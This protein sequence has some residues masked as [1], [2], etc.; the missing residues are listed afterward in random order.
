[1]APVEVEVEAEDE[2]E[3]KTMIKVTLGAEETLEDMVTVA[4]TAASRTT[5]LQ[6]ACDGTDDVI[7]ATPV[8]QEIQ[9]F[10]QWV[11][12]KRD[13]TPFRKQRQIRHFVNSCLVNLSNH[14]D[15]DMSDLISAL[16]SDLGSTRLKE[17]LL[18]PM[19][20]E[21]ADTYP[22]LSFQFVILPLIGALTRESLCQSTMS[23]E[24]NKIYATVYDYRRQFLEEG[25]IPCMDS[26]VQ[27]GSLEDTSIGAAQLLREDPHM[28][29]VT[30]LQ[31]ALLAIVRLF[32]QPLTRIRDAH[33][34][35]RDMVD[36]LSTQV[37]TCAM[38]SNTTGEDRF[39][40]DILARETGRLKRITA[41]AEEAV[42]QH[43]DVATSISSRARGAGVPDMTQLREA[44]DPPGELSPSG[45]RDDNDFV[46]I[47]DISILPTQQEITCT[48]D[49][50]LPSNGIPDA[51]HF[52]PSGWKRQI[53]IH[54][55]CTDHLL[56][57][58]ELR[59]HLKSNTH[60][61][62]YGN[63]KLLGMSTRKNAEGHIDLEFDQPTQV[64]GLGM[65]RRIDFWERSRNRLMHGGLICLM[66]RNVH[67]DASQNHRLIL[68]VI[69][70]R[71]SKAM[72]KNETRANI[73]VVLA[74]VMQFVHLLNTA[75]TQPMERWYIVES[76]G[77]YFGAYQP[78]LKALQNLIP[79]SLPFGKYLAPTAEEG[80][81]MD[82]V[83]DFIDPPIYALAPDFQYDLSVLLDGQ[84][85]NL[86]VRDALSIHEANRLLLERKCLDE[87]QTRALIDTLCREVSIINGPPGTGKTW[88]G[89][90]L[91]R[92]LLATKEASN[93]GPILNICYTNH[94]L[95][96][97]LE[98][99]LDVGIKD[100]VRIGGR[101]KS[102]R[103]EKYQL[104]ALT[105]GTLRD[106]FSELEDLTT[107]I[108]RIEECLKGGNV[109]WDNIKNYLMLDYPDLYDEF[110]TLDRSVS[111]SDSDSDEGFT[112]V[113]NKGW[114][115]KHPFERWKAGYD[116]QEAVQWNA[117]V[118][119]AF[120]QTA[121]TKRKN[122][123]FSL[124]TTYDDQ[125][126]CSRPDP[127]YKAVPLTDRPL[128]LLSANAFY[129]SMKERERLVQ[130]W[131]Q[132]IQHAM[133]ERLCVLSRKS[134]ICRKKKSDIFNE[135]NL[136]VLR[137]CAVI[138]ITTSGAAKAQ[139]LIKALAPKII[140]CEEA[141]EVLES[142]IL[143]ALSSSTQHLIL[144]GDHKQ[145]RPQVDT[146][147]LSSDSPGGWKYNLDKS[148]FERLVSST[149]N[150][151]PMSTLT[152][153]RRMRPCISD[154]IRKPLYP[155]LE[156]GD[157]VYKYPPVSGMGENLFFMHHES[158]EDAKDPFG[159]ESF[160]NMFE[161]DMVQALATHLIKNGYDQPG[162][163]AIL[164]PYLGQLS[165]LRDAL[166]SRFMLVIEGRDKDNLDAKDVERE[167]TDDDELG[168]STSHK[169]NLMV[170]GA[171]SVSLQDQLT[172]RTIDNYQASVDL[173]IGEEAK[174]III[175]LVRNHAAND[176]LFSSGRIGF[177]KSPNRTNVLLSRAKHGMFILGNATLMENPKNG[178]WP[179][180]I[181]KLRANDRVGVG[182]PLK[183]KNH[184]ETIQWVE[185][186][187]MLRIHAPNAGC[188]LACG[189]GMPCGHTCPLQCHPDDKAHQLVK[190]FQPCTRLQPICE[191]VC[192]KEC[193]QNCGDCMVIVDPFVLDC[194]H[195]FEK[196]RCFEKKN[197]SLIKCGVKVT[198]KSPTCEHEQTMDC[199][200]K[201]V[202]WACKKPCNG[203]LS[204]GHRCT[205]DCSTCQESFS[206]GKALKELAEVPRTNH[207]HCNIKCGKSLF[208]GHLCNSLC[209][210]DSQCP[211]CQRP[212][213]V[214]CA[215]SICS[216]PCDTPCT[217]CNE[218]CVW[219]CKHQGQC[220][221]PCGVPCDRLPC[222]KRCELK[223]TCG[224][225]C[226]SVCG[227]VCPA[228]RFCV[229]C[230][231][232]KTMSLQVDL[233]MQENLDQVDVDEDPVLVLNCGHAFTMTTLDSMM[234][235]DHYY[236]AVRDPKTDNTTFDS[237]LPLPNETVSQVTCPSC[238]KPIMR[239]CRYGRRIKD[240]QLSM[241]LKKHQLSQQHALEKAKESIDAAGI[242]LQSGRAA[243]LNRVTGPLRVDRPPGES[244]RKLGRFTLKSGEFPNTDISL[245]YNPYG[246]PKPQSKAWKETVSSAI[247]T[248]KMLREIYSEAASSP[249]KRLFEAAV[250][251]LYRMKTASVDITTKDRTSD[252]TS[253]EERKEEEDDG[254]T[255]LTEGAIASA[256]IQVCIRDCGL[257]PGGFSGPS[258]V[259]SLAEMTNVLLLIHSE[260]TAVMHKAGVM[261]GWYWFVEDLTRCC[262]V[263]ASMALQAAIEGHYPRHEAYARAALL[264]II[265]QLV[266]WMGQRSI[267]SDDKTK[268]AHFKRVDTLD[269]EFQGELDWISE[270]CPLGIKPELTKRAE[271]LERKM[272][273]AIKVARG[274][275]NQEI[276]AEE[277]MQVFRA[278][279]AKLGGSG[280]WYRCPNGH[281]FIIDDCGMAMQE[282]RCID[283][284]AA[285][286]GGDHQL[287]QSNSLDSEFE[288]FY[289][290]R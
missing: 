274:Q 273:I 109:S 97:F 206:K 70:G 251:H 194:G 153:Q 161:V 166:K 141:G 110:G 272:K 173:F 148:L 75:R 270:N 186:A 191:H 88:I 269:K 67:N 125:E 85:C 248:L 62:V 281:T 155:D 27:Q 279:S 108:K 28:R 257:P 164:T 50:F 86:D 201:S 192:P 239:L 221:M 182:L 252:S 139:E 229:V 119:R 288:G 217:A 259:E 149:T 156:D 150:P 246:I 222:N 48:R 89:V 176:T 133:T 78:V 214:A 232:P 72:A 69:T 245:N 138:G 42:I 189:Y 145:L 170:A 159:M 35:L 183:C 162:D 29:I 266:H 101:S 118:R 235:M 11:L 63:V 3:V 66:S 129:M 80:A 135:I 51:P 60:V 174:I 132:N 167:E 220:S 39:F 205:R 90:A 122:N 4:I 15:V 163:I 241:R 59:K 53:D 19:G 87:T 136:S 140:I 254:D 181:E 195:R 280:H 114:M 79:A 234:E 184:P 216:T 237:K 158:P 172:L 54:F 127:V 117:R 31:R 177:L 105:E 197:P 36:K 12:K 73:S 144:I 52:L 225:Q 255:G 61:N 102:T 226:P 126:S 111:D 277:K 65:G 5:T 77:A 265:Y 180:V 213:E 227:E 263:Y 40:N 276:S 55:R 30:S 130:H 203:D 258:L 45:K 17:I 168:T 230:K 112:H 264:N 6:V 7:V 187:D 93:C 236:N 8:A 96:Q 228:Q 253:S 37:R 146:Y 290:N 175:S 43:L 260:A 261:T 76:P 56:K 21:N 284:N 249:S 212:C 210:P 171:K 18:M 219:M 207:G 165:K 233:I 154:L 24:S 123:Q 46:D 193:G 200:M 32:Y 244:L 104:N 14:H 57:P 199:H 285:V 13:F 81:T 23:G 256:M 208:C 223:L 25:V 107:E 95:D 231:D 178:I 282:S 211:P 91:T 185:S 10:A 92:V 190:C 151:L 152:T 224:H 33:T 209:H 169:E 68:A 113:R 238:R 160:S 131:K 124:L 20:T 268:T 99:L 218:R 157:D 22:R 247:G 287:L 84:R 98:H 103:L 2:D 242:R 128:H 147:T 82:G 38:T 9:S 134:E 41:D 94:A 34:T 16:A 278:V 71:D 74:D 267:P 198:C 196:P 286:G 188:N 202:E 179:S 271:D 100:Q 1:M 143:T 47:A 275:L 289:R 121:K 283:C 64:K 262:T 243:L 215:H 204:C 116:I 240:A 137:R 115:K 49:P 58:K 106:V 120:E 250:S 142:H 26:L 83:H 44:F